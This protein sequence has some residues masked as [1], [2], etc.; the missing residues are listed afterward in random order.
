M[1]EKEENI[2]QHGIMSPY[3][4]EYTVS[5]PWESE[6]AETKLYV[7]G[8]LS[9]FSHDFVLRIMAEQL[10]LHTDFKNMGFFVW[11]DF[12]EKLKLKTSDVEKS[13]IDELERLSK[14]RSENFLDEHEFQIAKRK[15]LGPF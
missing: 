14:L 11:T 7:A 13:F 15:L 2:F 4:E 6:S 1:N 5:L 9:G 10:A 3:W 12:F 8:I